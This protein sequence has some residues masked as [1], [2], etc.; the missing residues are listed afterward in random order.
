MSNL[1][2]ITNNILADSGID[3]IN[4]VVTTG[5]YSNPAW[6]TALAWT[7]ITGTPTTLSGYGIT[8][9]YTKTEV[10]NIVANYLPLA[11][12][13]MTGQIVLKE[14]TDSTDYTKGLRFPNDPYGGGF[15]VSGL[16]LYRDGAGTEKVV[17]ELYVGNDG[18]GVS[19]DRINFR[20]GVG[21]TADNNLVTINDNIIWNAG[22]LTN[23]VSGTGTANQITYWTAASTIAALSTA[24]YPSLTELSY[25]KGVTSS[26]QTQLNAKQATLTLTTT[27]TSGAA[28]LVGATLNIP[29]YQSVL[30]NPVTGTGTT[31]YVTKWSS[32]STVTDSQIFDNGS[33]VGIGTASVLQGSE[34]LAVSS[35][36]NT[37]IFA[38]FT[39]GGNQGWVTKLWNNGTTGD[40]YILEFLTET[41][42]TQR[43]YIIYSR[44]EDRLAIDGAGSG[45]YFTGASSKFQNYI[46]IRRTPTAPVDVFVNGANEDTTGGGI[47]L[48]RYEASGSYR[49]SAIF[50]RY[51]TGGGADSMVFSV[52]DS[53]NP[54]ISGTTALD[55]RVKMLL[56]S[57]GRLII[58]KLTDSANGIIQAEGSI[59]T[60]SSTNY[61]IFANNYLRAYAAGA[62]YFDQATV[63]QDF[64]WRTSASSSLDSTPL[65]IKS[66]GNILVNTVTDSGYKVDISGTLRVNGS[67][68]SAQPLTVN[69]ANASE[70]NIAK[71]A[72]G[73]D[74]KNFYIG[75]TNN[76]NINLST[77]GYLRFRVGVT[78]DSPYSTGIT[79]MVIASDGKIALGSTFSNSFVSISGD[80]NIAYNTATTNYVYR[81]FAAVHAAG[82]RGAKMR[83]GM[84]DGGFAG[85]SV[86]N[87]A[88][89]SAGFNSQYI[90]FYTHEGNVFSD[91]VMRL[92]PIGALRLYSYG[93]GTRTG[94]PTYRLAVD[95]SG[96]VIEVTDGGG[97]VTGSGTAT[98]V[99][100]WDGSSSISSNSN[101]YWDNSNGRL[102]VGKS[103]ADS[104]LEV[105]GGTKGQIRANG[106]TA[107]G[108]GVD[109]YTEL[110]GTGRRNWGIQT[111]VQTAGDFSILKSASAGA[112]PTQEVFTIQNTGVGV[113]KYDFQ[114]DA[115]LGASDNNGLYL[116]GVGDVTHKLYYKTTGDVG[117]YLEINNTF[118]IQYY[119]GGSPITPFTFSTGGNLTATGFVSAERFTS[120]AID[121]GG[122]W[123]FFRGN[124][125][126][127]NA[128]TIYTYSEN[129]YNNAY[130]SYHIR[131]NN[132]GGT[133]GYIFLHGGSTMIGTADAPVLHSGTTGLVVKGSARGI[134]ELWDA[135]TGKSVF[136]NVSGDTYI[137]QLDK[138]T[139]SGR[140]FLLVNGNGSSA[141]VAMTL[142]SSGLVGIGDQTPQ[143]GLYVA[144]YGSKWDTDVQYNQ[145][146]G[147]I[148][149]SLG[150]SVSNQDNWFG[151]RG[152]YGSSTGSANLLLQANYRDVGSQAGHYVSSYGTGLGI[153]NFEIGKLVT[154]TSVSTPPTKVSQFAI[155]ASGET[156]IRNYV[157]V[158]QSVNA[159][160][161]NI[162]TE[163]QLYRTNGGDLY[164][165]SSGTGNVRVVEGGAAL[166]V[167]TGT[168]WNQEKFGI[169]ISNAAAWGDVPAMM[170]LTNY[171]SGYRTKITFTDSSIIDGWLGMVPSAAAKSYFVMG[172]AGYTEQ[173]FKV[174]QNGYAYVQNRLGVGVDYDAL[175]WKLNVSDV[176]VTITDGEAI[177]TSNMRGIMLENSNNGIESIGLWFRTGGN[178]LSG[179]SAQRTTDVSSWSTDL[180]FYTHPT[181]TSN[182]TYAFERVR[183]TSEGE[184][185]VGYRTD[186]G[187]YMLQVNGSTYSS[188]GF[189]ESSDIRLKTISN[190]HSSSNFDAIEFNWNDKRDSKLHW[191]YAAQEVM[192]YL[193]DAVNGTEEKFYTLDYTQVHTYKIAMLEK[194]IAELEQQLKTKQ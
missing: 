89:T 151:I 102:A 146:T 24:T 56:N 117:I 94:T 40:N 131:A 83:F 147:N 64:V 183:I 17:L 190:R 125:S 179:I 1:A 174:Y 75:A 91:I 169:Q 22:N 152:N 95:S 52:S 132:T 101:L 156:Q 10:D 21:G 39:G 74:E 11:G 54:Y 187:S 96:N 188:T 116:R 78:N 61:A 172:F 68:N 129:V 126:V 33:F 128:L 16:R 14:G 13:T 127:S 53:A 118:R 119:N 140:T 105:Y 77:E 35:S 157:V 3:D 29:Q 28:T 133:G 193:P 99:A 46:G 106:G 164:I 32:S 103:S 178:H 113:Y 87:V 72:R 51:I 88:S 60:S 47:A 49:G 45:L 93:S 6:I 86:E 182:L 15:D 66:N 184:L 37:A 42:L 9:A 36:T 135:T 181:S 23:P 73:N 162:L 149:L 55:G 7:K 43:G 69:G 111:E 142:L 12:G 85:M 30:T 62:F 25:V 27:G 145:P 65:T 98:R 120:N 2:T 44:A 63:G 4:V 175:G 110:S 138:G 176:G 19:Q 177:S 38:K 20:T 107:M 158:G 70:G 192:K 168:R 108:G 170:R 194:R 76:Q 136:Q 41:V 180:R 48:L 137:G 82:N 80:V 189:F 90:D 165:N 8:N 123:Y 154:S 114:A 121:V 109:I 139:G 31:N 97:T 150:Y 144:K 58:G 163:N 160:T 166:L 34:K 115:R 134:M 100:F 104:R 5:S 59:V 18:T 159:T 173:A 155:L 67:N 81:T 191:G 92:S 84:S 50:H 124:S 57:Y 161:Y 112:A 143:S 71:F 130:K 26:I 167:N 186:Q 153:A 141:D 185:W 122:E 79:A 148:F 171:G